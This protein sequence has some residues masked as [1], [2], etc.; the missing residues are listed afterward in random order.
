[1]TG[2]TIGKLATEAGVPIQTVRFYERRGLIA[3]PP[4]TPSGYR[5]YP[6][7]TVRRLRFIRRAKKLG[8]SLREIEEL[9]AL[10]MTPTV[11]CGEFREEI[12]GKLGD[13]QERIR[14]LG[15]MKRAL[16][17]LHALCE[18]TNPLGACPILDLLEEPADG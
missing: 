1:M 5:E 12:A 11:S 13:V 17:D 9:L 3:D 15:R 16:E 8:F 4:R 7:E 2:L 18:S 10:R 14:D 6:V